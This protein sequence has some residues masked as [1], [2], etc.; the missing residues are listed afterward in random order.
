MLTI[1]RS[2]HDTVRK[3]KLDMK[4]EIGGIPWTMEVHLSDRFMASRGNDTY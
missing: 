3:G 2:F 4:P 1:E